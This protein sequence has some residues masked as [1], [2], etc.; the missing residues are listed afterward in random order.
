M[1]PDRVLCP[2]DH[3]FIIQGQLHGREGH[4]LVPVV[5]RSHQGVVDPEIRVDPFV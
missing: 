1:V 4:E 2:E 3:E 5:V